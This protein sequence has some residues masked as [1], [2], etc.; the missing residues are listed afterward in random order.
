MNDL[1]AHPETLLRETGWLRSLVRH[2]VAD[3]DQ[4]E[5]VVQETLLAA[6]RTNPSPQ[7]GLRPWLAH[8]A[9]NLIRRS[10]RTDRHRRRREKQVA[11]PE[12]QPATVDLVEQIEA[13]RSVVDAVLGLREP[14]RSVIL[15][16]YFQQLSASE[17]ALA[18][19][20]R[21][22]TVYTRLRR[23]GK[24]GTRAKAASKPLGRKKKSARTKKTGTKQVVSK[25]AR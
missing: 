6:I 1:S 24:A 15:R 4:T 14:Y 12:D 7:I 3:E 8:V 25:V 11:K 10:W 2:L 13:Q 17:I 22:D 16:H 23:R 18:D 21:V 9:R 19:A 20:T 5:E